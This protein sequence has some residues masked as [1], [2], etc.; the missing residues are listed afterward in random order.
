[1][2]V[3][4]S[5]TGRATA[6]DG[7]PVDGYSAGMI[8]FAPLLEPV[9][10]QLD[11]LRARGLRLFSTSSFQT[12]SVPLLHILSKLAP[13]VPVYFLNTGFLFPETL[14]FRDELASAFGLT[15]RSVYA[16]VPRSQQLGPDGRFLF[17]S[18][19]DACC[20]LNKVAPMEPVLAAHDV[21][22]NGVRASQSETRAKMAE[23]QPIA[24]GKLRYHPMLGW[25]S[26]MVYHYLEQ[27]HLPRH[28]LEDAGYQ[29]IGC[30]PCTRRWTSDLDDRGGRWQGLKKS[31]CGLHTTLGGAP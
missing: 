8:D 13:E 25:T 27:H 4:C 16:A 22:I 26:R 9:A 31:E 1:M 29:S 24:D 17:A 20:H 21:W 15:V 6:S 3:Q 14:T 30:Q 28:P 18:D 7:A 5:E 19:P 12:N 23:L 10:E 2:G 11:G